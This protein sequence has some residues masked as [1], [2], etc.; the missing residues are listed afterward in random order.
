MEFFALLLSA[1]LLSGCGGGAAAPEQSEAVSAPPAAVSVPAPELEAPPAPE[2]V[3]GELDGMVICLDPGH[4]I[5]GASGQEK[6]SPLSGETK[7]AY[8]SGTSG[9][10]ITEEA[11]NLQVALRL[12]DQ[13]ESMGATVILTRET[14]EVTVSNIERAQI[15]NQAGADV[16]VRIHADGIDDRSV[17]G[18]SVLIPSGSLLGTPSIEQPSAALG[19]LMVDAVAA[20]TGAKNRGTTARTDLTGFNWSEVPCVLLEMGF[21]TNAAEEANLIDPAYQDK[22]AHGVAEA[23][24]RWRE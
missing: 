12:R 5:T 2:P 15:A 20:Q 8:V 21:L 19:Q 4:G 10:Q 18:V 3:P 16:C 1:L 7:A 14:N 6:L 23:L 9:A 17:H 22:I 13:L 11:L 24:V